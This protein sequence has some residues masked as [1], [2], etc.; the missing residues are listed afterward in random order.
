[1]ATALNDHVGDS[2]KIIRYRR[3]YHDLGQRLSESVSSQLDSLSRLG[4]GL[5]ACDTT[6]VA[7]SQAEALET[8]RALNLV[9][10]GGTLKRSWLAGTRLAIRMRFAIR[11]VTVASIR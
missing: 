1:M 8:R 7:V 3:H 10:P 9:P 2:V 4:F 6:S 5:C 11:R